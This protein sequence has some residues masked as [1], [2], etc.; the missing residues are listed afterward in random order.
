[1]AGW[2]TAPLV[3]VC[4]VF[5]D[6]DWIESKDQ[7]PDGVRLVQTG[8]I[9]K[10][11][12]KDRAEKARFVSQDTFTRL[13][14]TEIFPGDCLISRLPDPVGRACL[15]PETDE[16]MITAVDCTIVRFNESKVLPEF[17]A[18]YSQA[19]QYLA[20]VEKEATGT[21][22]K[23][24]SRVRLGQV[25]IP[26]APLPEQHRIV[27]ILDEA[28]DAIATAKANTEKSI[29]NVREMFVLQL[30]NII[31][32]QGDGHWV[33]ATIGEV[34]TLKSGT[35][36]PIQIERDSGDVPYVKVAEL[37]MPDNLDGVA[38][39]IRFVNQTDIK[40]SWLIPAGAVIFPKRGGAILTNKKRLTLVEL[41]ADL[42]LMAVI[43]S[44]K[45]TSDFL[46]LY[47]L[48]VDMRKIGSGSSIPQINNYDIAPLP[49]SFPPSREAQQDVTK[50]IRTIE[51]NCKAIE[52]LWEDK[53][54]ALDELKK[55]LLHQAFT[56][57]LTA[58]NT[59]KQL[60]AVA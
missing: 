11:E 6:G 22:R 2:K 15:I 34:C 49:I 26:L 10:G 41:C 52:N 43:P 9:G 37:N 19:S 36:L 21:T 46:Y 42:N 38:T 31:C 56:G 44:V 8:N 18:Y 29:L 45:I 5:G 32:D 7:S 50:R 3:S 12:F 51:A 57:K 14:C 20:A 54:A 35:T 33:H 13:R 4:T 58:K 17:F 59:D 27:A 39:S 24:I 40:P 16:R 25:P 1:M 30:K 53:L 28:F 23:R 48:A 47:F 55:S 60:E